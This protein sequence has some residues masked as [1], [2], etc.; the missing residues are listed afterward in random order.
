MINSGKSL[1]A[2]ELLA[3]VANEIRVK[4]D[5]SSIHTVFI[6]IHCFFIPS[7]PPETTA[8]QCFIEKKSSIYSLDR[9]GHRGGNALSKC[10]HTVFIP[11]HRFFIPPHPPGTTALQS[12]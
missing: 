2:Q 9:G 5:E 8:L 12:F 1:L 3:P 6:P 10:A 7:Q 11:I 4:H